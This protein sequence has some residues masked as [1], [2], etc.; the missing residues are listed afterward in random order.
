MVCTADASG[1]ASAFAH[2]PPRSSTAASPHPVEDAAQRAQAQVHVRL[3]AV[4]PRHLPAPRTR[5]EIPR[6]VLMPLLDAEKQVNRA[7]A[8]DSKWKPAESEMR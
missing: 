2:I 1:C 3:G 6:W 8:P 4:Q 7:D 5:L